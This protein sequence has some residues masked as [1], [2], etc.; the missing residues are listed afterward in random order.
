MRTEFGYP[1]TECACQDCHKN[2]RFMPGFLIPADLIRMIP[3]DADAMKWAATYL[4]ASPGAIAMQDGV[5]FRIGT[6]VPAVKPDGSCIHLSPE[7][8]CLI[9]E[10]APFGCAFFDCGPERGKL[11]TQGLLAV[12][13]AWKEK[14]LYSRIWEFLWDIDRRQQGPEVLRSRMAAAGE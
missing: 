6:L 11:S 4:L 1:R 8:S 10:I 13:Q 14:A 7:G 9:H 12:M 5:L 3:K 2:C